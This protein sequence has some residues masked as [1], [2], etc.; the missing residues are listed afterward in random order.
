MIKSF[1]LLLCLTLLVEGVQAQ[2]N[3]CTV[4][5]PSIPADTLYLGTFSD[6]YKNNPYEDQISFRLPYTTT[7]LSQFGVPAGI[8]IS[9]WRISDVEGLPIGLNYTFDRPLNDLYDEAAPETRD[10][11]MTICGTPFQEGTFTFFLKAYIFVSIL[12]DVAVDLPVN[13]TILPDSSS[14]FSSTQIG[15]DSAWVNFT[16]LYPSNGDPGCTYSWDFGNGTTSVLE[17]PDSVFYASAGTYIVSYQSVVDTFPRIMH[18]ITVLATSCNDDVPPF[19]VN[20]PDLYLILE[21]SAA[22]ELINNDWNTQPFI[23]TPPDTYPPYVIFSGSFVLDPA[24]TYTIRVMDDDDDDMNTDDPGGVFTISDVDFAN[25]DTIIFMDSTGSNQ[26][27]IITS[28][29]INITNYTDSIIIDTCSSTASVEAPLAAIQ[30]VSVYPNPSNG[31]F[32]L[33]TDLSAVTKMELL[34]IQGRRIDAVTVSDQIDLS[35]YEIGTY[36]LLVSFGDTQQTVKLV[37]Y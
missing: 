11:C 19:T 36:Y 18:K 37:R 34:N 35:E 7:T 33:K 3:G 5:I 29:Y 13:I 24:E 27:E 4:T 17:N 6:G 31:L 12:G 28:K 32:F 20:A 9:S 25:N 14:A 2:C 30:P 26:I 21:N 16:N 10:G 23:G 1:S 15:C 22:V 8:N